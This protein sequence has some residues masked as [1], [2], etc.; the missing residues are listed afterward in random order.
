MNKKKND[1]IYFGGVNEKILKHIKPKEVILDIG[2]SDGALGKKI[3]ELYG[4][5]VFGIELYKKAAD[6]AKKRLDKVVVGDIERIQIPFPKEYFD[7]V[8]F[9]DVIE[10]TA[11]PEKVLQK[12]KPLLKK[13]GRIL[14]SIPNIANIFVRLKLLFGKFNYEEWGILD[15]N[16]LRFFTLDSTKELIEGNGFKIEK[17]EGRRNSM[18]LLKLQA[19]LDYFKLLK[20]YILLDDILSNAWKSLFAQQFI[21]MA[22]KK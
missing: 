15:R 22:R 19:I 9:A 16:H 8:I 4:N 3:K 7:S 18:H 13:N 11:E 10:H 20:L 21:I 5:K 14:V 6:I 2:C 17:I 1:D 12:V